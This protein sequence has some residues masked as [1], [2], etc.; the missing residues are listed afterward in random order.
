MYI[1]KNDRTIELSNNNYVVQITEKVF[2]GYILKKFVKDSPFDI[3]EI[4]EIRVPISEKEVISQGKELLKMRYES[5][6]VK[7]STT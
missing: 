7:F 3:L 1:E 6:T 4:R 2:G 5:L